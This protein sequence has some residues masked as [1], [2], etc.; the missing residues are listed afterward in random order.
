[1]KYV[2]PVAELVA[3]EA[4]SVILSS[5]PA[6]CEFYDP[7]CPQYCNGDCSDMTPDL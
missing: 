4:V 2:S 5:A 7:E 3:L 1:M 6:D